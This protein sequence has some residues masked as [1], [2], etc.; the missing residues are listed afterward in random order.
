[1]IESLGQLHSAIEKLVVRNSLSRPAFEY[2]VDS[3]TLFA[4]K[5]AI[6]QVRVVN[7]LGNNLHLAVANPEIMLQGL[8]S[9]G[10]TAMSEPP[11]EQVKGHRSMRY[12]AFRRKVNSCLGGD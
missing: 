7:N 9:A 8:E 12:L 1:M 4:T 6:R 3:I 2:L 10:V 11:F 5:L